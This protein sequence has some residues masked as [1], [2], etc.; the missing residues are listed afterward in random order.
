MRRTL[1]RQS[2]QAIGGDVTQPPLAA[3]RIADDELAHER[4][5]P[6]AEVHVWILGGEVAAAR[7]HL[8]HEPAAVAEHSGHLRSRRELADVDLQPVAASPARAQEDEPAA[9]LGD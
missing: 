6:E 8:A 4:R 7:A 3:V 9:D 5:A 1:R 2:Q